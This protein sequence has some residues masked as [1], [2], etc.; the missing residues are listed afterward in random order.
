M[1]GADTPILTGVSMKYILFFSET[2]YIYNVYITPENHCYCLLPPTM[3]TAWWVSTNFDHSYTFRE[4]RKQRAANTKWKPMCVLYLYIDIRRIPRIVSSQE[5]AS[6][7]SP[8]FEALFSTPGELFRLLLPLPCRARLT[9]EGLPGGLLEDSCGRRKRKSMRNRL[10][11][12]T[13]MSA[14]EYEALI[15]RRRCG[16]KLRL[17]IR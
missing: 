7:C 4:R 1:F 5:W 2:I 9:R 6:E 3:C 12:G 11:V 10:N 15:I 13:F 16:T 8:R 14:S 17:Y